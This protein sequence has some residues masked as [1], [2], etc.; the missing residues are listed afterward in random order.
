MSKPEPYNPFHGKAWVLT[1]TWR[2]GSDHIEGIALDV[3]AASAWVHSANMEFGQSRTSTPYKI[4]ELK[5]EKLGVDAL[6]SRT[7]EKETT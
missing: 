1:E 4:I 3:D 5:P 6:S 2:D 7:P